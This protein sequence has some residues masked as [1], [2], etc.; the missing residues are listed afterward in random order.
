MLAATVWL[1]QLAILFQMLIYLFIVNRLK[2]CLKPFL[3]AM[4]LKRHF[5]A[6]H[7]LLLICETC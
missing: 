5:N 3:Q 2:A 1:V 7:F 4:L 6:I